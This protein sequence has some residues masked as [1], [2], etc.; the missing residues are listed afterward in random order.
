MLVNS[1]LPGQNYC[2]PALD[3]P[4]SVFSHCVIGTRLKTNMWCLPVRLN[5]KGSF[6]PY[7]VLVSNE[8]NFTQIYSER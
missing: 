8:Y 4:L 5:C 2:N 3:K 7:S 1:Q 6:V